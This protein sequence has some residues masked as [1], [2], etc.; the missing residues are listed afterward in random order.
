MNILYMPLS[1]QK[2]A[3]LYKML[4][5]AGCWWI[6]HTHGQ[7]VFPRG[8][9]FKTA[10]LIATSS[11]NKCFLLFH[12][13]STVRLLI[14]F[15]LI[16]LFCLSL[17]NTEVKN[18][19]C[20]IFVG[21]SRFLFFEMPDFVFCSFSIFVVCLFIRFIGIH[22]SFWILILSWLYILKISTP[23]LWHVFVVSLDEQKFLNL[24][25]SKWS[26]FSLWITHFSILLKYP[27]LS[28]IERHSLMPSSNNV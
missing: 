12:I 23:A 1:A 19:F 27:A 17:I 18:V 2:C 13:L 14:F 25:Q 8:G 21:Q 9:F 5:V 6:G 4:Q 11:E 26:N 10:A 22:S 7:Q 28:E 20:H 16:Y 3:F 15:N 24:M